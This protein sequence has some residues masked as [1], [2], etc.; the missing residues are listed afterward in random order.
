MDIKAAVQLIEASQIIEKITQLKLPYSRDAL[1]PCMSKKCVSVHYDIL[2]KRYFDKYRET[3]DLFQKAGAVLHNDYYWPMMKAYTKNN[4]P[5]DKIS[6]MILS[7]HGSI[8]QF[9]TAVLEAAKSVQGNGWVLIMQDMQIQTVQNHVLKP[10]ILWAID[11]WEHATVDHDY[12][13]E[14][15]FK[16]YWN[17]VD[18]ETIEKALTT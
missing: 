12:N 16:H 6:E 18:W 17:I 10:G 13:R 1:E 7:S 15:F 4:K 2:T 8:D 11:I 9:K 3:G 5:G 14:E